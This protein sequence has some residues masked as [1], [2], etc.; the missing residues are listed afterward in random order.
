MRNTEKAV[1]ILILALW[2]WVIVTWA[3]TSFQGHESDRILRVELGSD[4]ASLNQ[5]VAA[6]DRN[7]R[8]GI[9]HNVEMVVRNTDMDFVF[10][11]LYWLTF[12]SLS[13]LAGRLGRRFLA[14]CAALSISIAALSDLF[15]NGAILTA[16]RVRP[17]TDA[18]A[19]DISEFSQ[20]KWSFFFLASLFLGLAIAMNHRVS[21]M[22]RASGGIFITAGAIGILGMSRYR[23]SLDFTMLLINVG[24]LL[25]GAALLLTVWKIYLSLKELNHHLERV[26]PAH[27]HA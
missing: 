9:A 25:F 2:A 15:E 12:L 20:W 24:L 1:A 22:R 27:V 11:L 23:V 10:I 21:I 14:A 17:F 4:A 3:A 8:S 7:D 19:V 6:N 18:V 5:A 16:M 13:F 26:E